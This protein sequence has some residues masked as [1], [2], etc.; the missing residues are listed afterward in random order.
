MEST[1]FGGKLTYLWVSLTLT[2]VPA[3]RMKFRSLRIICIWVVSCHRPPGSCGYCRSAGSGVEP[4]S[5]APA[6]C[7]RKLHFNFK[8]TLIASFRY[9]CS[10]PFAHRSA[11]SI[12]PSPL[13]LPSSSWQ[14]AVWQVWHLRQAAAGSR[15]GA[16]RVSERQH[17][18]WPAMSG[19][20]RSTAA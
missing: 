19:T 20:Y 1:S 4:V 15:C 3:I 6:T 7:C 11:I 14:V 5:I 9:S 17:T 16:A 18:K 12:S 8:T 2:Y 10:P 13:P